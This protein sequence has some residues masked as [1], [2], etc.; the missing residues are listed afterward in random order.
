VDDGVSAVEL[1]PR[2]PIPDPNPFSDCDLVVCCG[3]AKFTGSTW[4]S[5]GKIILRLQTTRFVGNAWGERAKVRQFQSL[6]RLQVLWVRACK[7]RLRKP[8]L[9]LV[10][11]RPVDLGAVKMHLSWLLLFS[12][13][14]IVAV[15]R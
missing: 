1:S 3:G 11:A 7:G 6:G 12:N 13:I 5:T 14:E 4:A 9:H 10:T 2:L 8:A 15:V